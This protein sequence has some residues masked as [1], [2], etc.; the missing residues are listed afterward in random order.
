MGLSIKGK[1][2]SI[3]LTFSHIVLK[4]VEPFSLFYNLYKKKTINKMNSFVVVSLLT[5]KE[6]FWKIINKKIV[7]S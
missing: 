5:I 1:F 2:Y 6:P 4:T 3:E 7:N